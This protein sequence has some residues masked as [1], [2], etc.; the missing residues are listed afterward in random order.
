[1]AIIS[2]F[3]EEETTPQ[4]TTNTV[5]S[6]NANNPPQQPPSEENKP[7]RLIPNKNNGLD[8]DNYSWGQSLE[9]VTI[10]VPVPK[11][12]KARFMT[13]EIKNTSIK[14]Y[15]KN[16]ETPI[17]EGDFFKPVKTEESFW[18]LEDGSNVSILLTK[19]DKMDWWKSLFEG[20]P[21]IDTQKVEPEP[22]KLSDLDLETRS[23]VEKMMFDQ[24][25]KE[26]GLPTSKEIEDQ[27]MMKKMMEQHPEM[28]KQ[29]ANAKMMGNMG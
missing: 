27:S 13:F 19:V 9:E 7:E 21:V 18:S 10:N 29:F 15:L 26:M 1:M 25:Q 11:G 5:V 23:T 24:R 16:Q 17:L 28:A 12:T 8:M 22:S 4:T 6:T 3:N 14:L 2:D 20:G